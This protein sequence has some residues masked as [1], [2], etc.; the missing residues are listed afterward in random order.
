MVTDIPN[1][2]TKQMQR[3]KSQLIILKINNCSEMD[4]TASYCDSLISIHP[5]TC[6]SLEMTMNHFLVFT[7]REIK[8]QPKFFQQL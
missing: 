4:E 1:L 2:S 7:F 8:P 5:W 6:V 3:L